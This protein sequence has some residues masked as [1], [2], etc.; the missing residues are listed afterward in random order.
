[1]YEQSSK[2][3]MYYGEVEPEK[4]AEFLKD[5]VEEGDELDA[6]RA[7]LY[8]VRHHGQSKNHPVDRYFAA[9]FEM[10]DVPRNIGFLQPSPAKRTVKILQSMGFSQVKGQ[11]NEHKALLY[12]EIRNAVKRYLSTCNGEDNARMFMCTM[13]SSDAR[14]NT[15]TVEDIWAITNG[16]RVKAEK[17]MKDDEKEDLALYVKAVQDEFYVWKDNAKSWYEELNRQRLKTK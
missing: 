5:L 1:M 17:G 15:K 2:W 3:E 4:R 10:M 11:D 16:V 7:K 14:K 6:L 9:F 12:W 8:D 13:K